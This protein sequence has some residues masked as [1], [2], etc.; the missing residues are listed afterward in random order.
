MEK[1]KE[2]KCK[3]CD[4]FTGGRCKRQFPEQR[5]ANK[6]KEIRLLS[7]V[8]HDDLTAPEYNT[9]KESEQ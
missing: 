2:C 9:L 4:D 1:Q 7:E 5:K 3:N 6:P 8:M